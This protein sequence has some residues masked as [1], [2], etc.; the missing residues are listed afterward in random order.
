MSLIPVIL[1]KY[2]EVESVVT[3]H[4]P[5]FGLSMRTPFKLYKSTNIVPLSYFTLSGSTTSTDGFDPETLIVTF[6]IESSIS[7]GI[8][9]IPGFFQYFCINTVLRLFNAFFIYSRTYVYKK[10]QIFCLHLKLIVAV[11]VYICNKCT[12]N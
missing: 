4:S 1:V 10:K 6:L 9:F 11:C 2:G 12:K 7:T 8:E 5:D 3:N